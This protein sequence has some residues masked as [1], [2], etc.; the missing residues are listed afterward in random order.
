MGRERDRAI[1]SMTKL[2]LSTA[3]NYM[4]AYLDKKGKLQ[5]CGDV[6]NVPDKNSTVHEMAIRGMWADGARIF[7]IVHGIE[8][9]FSDQEN[10]ARL[11]EE[12]KK[13]RSRLN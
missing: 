8:Q 13:N 10:Q 9:K 4:L 6:S 2:H 12:V 7:S 5:F 3:K 1:K 11:A